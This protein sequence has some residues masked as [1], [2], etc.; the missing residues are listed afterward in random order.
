[1]SNTITELFGC[2]GCGKTYFIHSMSGDDTYKNVTET[3]GIKKQI[4]NLAKKILILTPY[5][6]SIRKKIVQNIDIS[7]AKKG[8]YTHRTVR[9]TV[10]NISMLASVYKYMNRKIY[11]DEGIVHRVISFCIDQNLPRETAVDIIASLSRELEP[12]K[13]FYLDTPPSVCYE[14]I[15][16]RGRKQATI[17]FL[18]KEE[19]A[20][21]LDEYYEYC[22]FVD[23]W[24]GFER[25]S[26]K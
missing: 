6:A 12:V 18:N 23:N 26:R 13:V 7:P 5:A 21:M 1:M 22:E 14:A 24:F 8:R 25:I 17:D 2:P 11:M 3:N 15:L 20:V 19:I 9:K 10:R 4:K 16:K